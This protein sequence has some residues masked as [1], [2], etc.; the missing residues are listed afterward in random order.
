MPEGC[1]QVE[2]Y[3]CVQSGLAAVQGHRFNSC[4]RENM[5]PSFWLCDLILLWAHLW[6]TRQNLASGSIQF[7]SCSIQF[8]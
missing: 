1:C 3:L 6:V 8:N 4:C 7:K 2:T 5:M